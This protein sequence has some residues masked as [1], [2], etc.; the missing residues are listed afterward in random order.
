MSCLRVIRRA[1]TMATPPLRNMK[2]GPFIG[3]TTR[4][5]AGADSIQ[6]HCPA[7]GQ[8]MTTVSSATPEQVDDAI[9]RSHAVF[10][11]GV[12]SRASPQHRSLVLSRIAAKLDSK[13]LLYLA[14]TESKQTGRAVRE[15]K[16]QL[17]R[18][19]EWLTYYAALLRTYQGYVPPTQGQVLSYVTR[20]PLGVVAQI[21]PFNHPLLIAIKKLTP[22]LAAGNSVI[23]KPS[24]LAPASVLDFAEL[25]KEAGLPDDVLQILPGDGRTVGTQIAQNPLVRKVDI[26]AG[27]STGRALGALVGGNLSAFTAELGGKAPA[28]VFNDADLTASVNGVAFAA[29]VAS[30]QTCVSGARIIVQ[31]GI[32]KAFVTSL[33]KKVES[34]TR[35]IGHPLEDSSTMGPVISQKALSRIETMLS[36]TKGTVLAGGKRMTGP[37]PLDG[38]NLS[39]GYF[40]PPTIVKLS[41]TDD[42]LWKEEIFGPVIV[43]RR[44]SEEAE[45]VQLANDSKYGL[46]SSIWTSDL[47]TAHRVARELE[48]GLVWVNTAHRNDPSSPWGGM[49]ES[50][51]GRENGVE[52]FESYTQSKTVLVN[53]ATPEY[54]RENED[55]FT[56]APKAVR[57]G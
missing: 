41:D 21:T 33:L 31:D 43:I 27:T 32:Y 46:G 50:G 29:F 20:E 37:S 17:A 35:R 24:E 52:A 45:G 39:A 54:M 36:Q 56:E 55:W 25:A 9:S 8:L 4:V 53:V 28:I 19:P 10:Q 11:S 34:I 15:M 7:T 14:I 57:Y 23:V 49:K 44:F 30:G 1:H 38:C 2:Y 5:A 47:G 40:F 3:G 51:I 6:V 48:H 22:A 13:Q 18:L 16:T 12:W 26:T 42:E